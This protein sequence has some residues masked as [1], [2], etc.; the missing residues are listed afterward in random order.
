MSAFGQT[1]ANIDFWLIDSLA[2]YQLSAE[3]STAI[4]KQL[5]VFHAAK[6]DS[7]RLATLE[8]II[9]NC[10]NDDVWPLYNQELRNRAVKYAKQ[11]STTEAKNTMRYFEAVSYGNT[12]YIHDTRGHREE[13]Q[14]DYQQALS[15]FESIG[16]KNGMSMIYNALAALNQTQGK[17]LDAVDMYTK[18]LHLAQEQKDHQA[19]SNA[20]VNIGTL[21]YGLGNNQEA[22]THL[23]LAVQEA[24]LLNDSA[25][26]GYTL[27]AMADLEASEGNYEKAKHLCLKGLAF[28]DSAGIETQLPR[29]LMQMG[30]LALEQKDT[31]TAR[32]YFERTLQIAN[33]YQMAE[34]IAIASHNLASLKLRTGEVKAAEKL[35]ARSYRIADLI[36]DLRIKSRASRV[37]SDVFLQLGQPETSLQYFKT[38]H[39]LSDSLLNMEVQ[40][41]ALRKDLQYKHLQEKNE[42]ERQKQA[43][44]MLAAE[45]QRQ[46]RIIIV[47]VS[48]ILII[49]VA[50]LI[51]IFS[52]LRVIRNQKQKL[53]IAYQKLEES[54][55]NE[56]LVS[57][58]KALQSQMNPHFIFNALNSI[59]SLVLDG[60]VESSYR[61]ITRFADLVRK[62]LNYSQKEWISLSDD[63]SLLEVYLSLEKLR[64]KEDFEY[65]LV[66][67]AEDEVTVP[68]MLVQPF[69]ENA[70]VHGLI[71]KA[72]DRKLS[73]RFE[74]KETLQCVITDNGI[75][76]KAA[77]EIQARRK[78]KHRSFAV[79]ATKARFEMLQAQTQQSVGFE[80]EDLLDERNKACGTRVTLRIPINKRVS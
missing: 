39:L 45:K 35:A 26:Y 59:Q 1:Y 58:L 70:L 68:P 12:A 64:F 41:E 7:A 3:D 25:E 19:A 17:V 10:W 43:E 52:R 74:L 46:Q 37:L 56:L 27:T 69:I 73:V 55:R 50:A 49:I 76:R 16:S 20:A 33:K 30:Y 36:S 60:D 34:N 77:Q 5:T 28:L 11:A 14:N 13:A 72:T 51:I 8:K 67:E 71:H 38:F 47:S 79:G 2:Q 29:G 6:E 32:Q 31:T 15:I 24:K 63:I 4:H 75:G 61:Y 62:T 66:N 57:N 18:S 22:R 42:L 78:N 23:E 65:E 48:V 80:I 21:H 9:D 40:R 53:D 54:K 44:L